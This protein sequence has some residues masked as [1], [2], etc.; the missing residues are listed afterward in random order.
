LGRHP[1]IQSPH[2]C[3]RFG[4]ASN[5]SFHLLFNDPTELSPCFCVTM[6]SSCDPP[7]L[8]EQPV[9]VLETPQEIVFPNTT[10]KSFS[11]NQA[12]S[13]N[14]ARTSAPIDGILLANSSLS[15]PTKNRHGS[16]L[17]PFS[18]VQPHLTASNRI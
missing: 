17:H 15:T 6:M 7:K 18:F 2:C 14:L 5:L 9:L 11:V 16:V 10:S 4:A 3:P 8:K 1:V 13:F 12:Q